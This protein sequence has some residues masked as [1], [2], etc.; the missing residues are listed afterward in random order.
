MPSFLRHLNPGKTQKIV[1]RKYLPV[2]EI[3]C[4]FAAQK[5]SIKVLAE[6]W[7]LQNNSP[8]T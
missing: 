3:I 6:T 8:E 4:T 7:L 5:K 1:T 2:R